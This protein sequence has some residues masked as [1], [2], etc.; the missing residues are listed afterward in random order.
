MKITIA[1]I[2][3]RLFKETIKVGIDGAIYFFKGIFV[4]L[5]IHTGG[6]VYGKLNRFTGSQIDE[7]IRIRSLLMEQ[8]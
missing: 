5:E 1:E 7:I 3:T 6:E 8:S 2:N 4:V